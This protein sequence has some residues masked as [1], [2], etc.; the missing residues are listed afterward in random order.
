M[1]MASSKGIDEQTAVRL[2]DL[3]ILRGKKEK[4]QTFVMHNNLDKFHRHYA[5]REKHVST[6]AY[7]MLQLYD[8]LKGKILVMENTVVARGLG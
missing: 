5:E 4:E 6:I 3:I 7:W 8:I 1:Q 2:N